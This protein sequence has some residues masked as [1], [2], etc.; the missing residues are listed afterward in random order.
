M[1]TVVIAARIGRPVQSASVKGGMN[2][3][4]ELTSPCV[5]ESRYTADAGQFPPPLSVTS[6]HGLLL[7][8]AVP[9]GASSR[10][11]PPLAQHSQ[12]SFQGREGCFSGKYFCKS[13]REGY[14]H[15]SLVMCE[16]PHRSLWW[17]GAPTG[18][19]LTRGVPWESVSAQ[20]RRAESGEE[21]V[22][23]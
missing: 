3:L 13:P 22:R 14:R 5:P 21:V 1:V 11:S 10:W 2:W 16:V 7:R 19:V 15:S 4:P 17:V 23:L 8:Q 18:Q 12:L 20:E 6:P 9:R